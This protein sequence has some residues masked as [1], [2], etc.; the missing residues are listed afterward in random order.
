LAEILAEYIYIYIAWQSFLPSLPWPS[1]LAKPRAKPSQARPAQKRKSKECLH[2]KRGI[3][4][5]QNKFQRAKPSLSRL[6]LPGRNEK[7]FFYT[8]RN[9]N[10]DKNTNTS[11]KHTHQR[12]PRTRAHAVT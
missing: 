8:D 3:W 2:P 11:T 7:G 1:K 9:T 5:S 10:T 6:V 12:A 4:P